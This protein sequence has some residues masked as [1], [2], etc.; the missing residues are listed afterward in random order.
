MDREDRP[1]DRGPDFLSGIALPPG[2]ID[3]RPKPLEEARFVFYDI[4]WDENIPDD[5]L[6]MTGR[7]SMLR[8][9]WHGPEDGVAIVSAIQYLCA[10]DMLDC[11]PWPVTRFKGPMP[12]GAVGFLRVTL[13]T[14]YVAQ[15]V[16][17]G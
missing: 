6:P 15:D 8:V 2:V 9:R 17:N 7:F 16:G 3:L 14:M 1:Y 4:R 12:Q 10:P 5:A 11:L 13:E